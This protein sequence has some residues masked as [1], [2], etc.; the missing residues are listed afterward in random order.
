MVTL[1]QADPNVRTPRS[2]HGIAG[3]FWRLGDVCNQEVVSFNDISGDTTVTFAPAPASTDHTLY[4]GPLSAVSTYGYSGSV[5]GLGATGTS[6]LNLPSGDLFW[7]VVG[8]DN[9]AEGGYGTGVSERP[10]YG[11]AVVP[12][13]PN[14]TG[15]CSM[16]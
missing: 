8:R 12:Q 5:T 2:A 14:R 16:P 3:G 15:Q 11:G 7:V 4:Y 10:P 13:D 6:A 9:G 1:D